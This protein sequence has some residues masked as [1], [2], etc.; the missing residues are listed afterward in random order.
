MMKS[1][2]EKLAGRTVTGEQYKAIEA[3]Y[4]ES[5]LDKLDFVKSMK[6]MLKSIP[7]Q[8]ANSRIIIGVKPMPNGTW[9]TYEAELVDV[10]IATGKTIVKRLSPNRCWAETGFDIWAGKVTEA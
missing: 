4:M 9:M 7:E 3:L 5:T 6:A 1:E 2:F 10:N 8:H